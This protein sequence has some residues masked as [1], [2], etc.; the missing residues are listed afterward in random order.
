VASEPSVRKINGPAAEPID[1]ADMA[2][3]A[4]LKRL[5]PIAAIV[6]VLALVLRRRR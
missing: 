1:M 3:A 2:G 4:L 6:M 5:A